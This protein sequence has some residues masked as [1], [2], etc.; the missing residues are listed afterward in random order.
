MAFPSSIDGFTT[1]VDNVDNVLATHMNSVQ[2]AVAAIEAKLGVDASAVT[3]SFDYFLK[4]TSGTFK[5][6][7][8]NG[9]D[10]AKFTLANMSD[11]NISAPSNNQLL[12]YNTTTSKWENATITQALTSLTDVTISTPASRESIYYNG[13]AW[14]NGNPNA[15]YAS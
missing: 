12:R 8:H 3:T 7:T 11:A 4:H 5:T 15:V 9:V 13:S 1:K 14:Q 6:H 10:S 2:S